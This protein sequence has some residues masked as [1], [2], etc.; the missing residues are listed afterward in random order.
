MPGRPV[1]VI[2]EDETLTQRFLTDVI[3]SVADC[4]VAD[5]VASGLL[6][7]SESPVNT[8][9]LDLILPNGQG[10]EVLHRFR[11][12]FPDVPIV[13]I[14]GAHDVDKEALLRAGAME[15]L[16]K[17]VLREDVLNSIIWAVAR[18]QSIQMIRPTSCLT[19][20]VKEEIAH[21]KEKVGA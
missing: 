1:I 9:L 7:M 20:E 21:E 10:I 18:N 16:Y 3:K 11:T 17:P 8:L 5:T 6:V 19:K 14:T 13:V 4:K 12:A 15:V 2:V